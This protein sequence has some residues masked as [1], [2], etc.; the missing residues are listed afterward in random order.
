MRARPV[1][2]DAGGLRDSDRHAWQRL[3]PAWHAAFGGLVVLTAALVVLDDGV[4]PGARRIALA[5]VAALGLWY[6]TV[7]V[8][9][10]RTD[11]GRSGHLYVVVAA[12]LTLALFAATPVGALMLFALY[13]HIWRMLPPRVAIVAT[14]AVVA[15]V[16]A[17]AVV[18]AGL[19]G[20]ALVGWLVM[21]AVTLAV[22]LLLGLW[23]VNIIE[24]SQRR[25]DLLAE[26]AATRAELDAANREAGIIAERERLAHEIHDTIAQGCTSVLLL[27]EA[28]ES[29]VDSDPVKA[30]RYLRRAQE[31]TRDN[32][33]EARALVAAL[34]PPELS[35]TSLPE[36][37]RRIVERAGFTP[38][39][40][41]E[42]VV[43]GT[44][45]GLPAEREVA[46]LRV[47]QEA[48][49]N[50]RRHAAA[51]R[52]EVDLAYRPECVSLRVCDDGRGFD[53]DAP[54]SGDGLAGMRA[55][56]TRVGGVVSVTA[57]PGA[58]AVVRFDLPTRDGERGDGARADR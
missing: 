12:G 25:A 14:V 44:P 37:L 2:R 55:R 31:T 53:P 34:T 30:M 1:M 3:G 54:R 22:G 49:T 40:A 42:L 52:V 51:T 47:T 15:A 29:A 27:L 10:F 41:A 26:L 11:T 58:G 46:M 32:L 35:S 13:P 16:T 18:N 33:A 56:A 21:S 45:R 48:L 36:A 8:A 24:Q 23:I 9:A 20:P 50:V 5:L 28:G 57:A 6:A 39:P 19:D 38:G 43:S 4:Q 7:G 17:I